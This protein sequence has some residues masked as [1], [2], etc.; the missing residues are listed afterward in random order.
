MIAQPSS[1]VALDK[2]AESLDLTPAARGD[3]SSGATVEQRRSCARALR[4]VFCPSCRR[5]RTM[6]F[7]LSWALLTGSTPFDRFVLCAECLP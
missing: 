4:A 2:R 6:D 1:F 3:L 5:H 7:P